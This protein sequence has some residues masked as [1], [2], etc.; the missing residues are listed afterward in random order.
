MREN[1][2]NQRSNPS[3]LPSFLVDVNWDIFIL[4]ARAFAA[5]FW[6]EQARKGSMKKWSSTFWTQK[7]PR[8]C[9]VS[10]E[11]VPNTSISD[12]TQ[13]KW[14]LDPSTRFPLPGKNFNK[15][16]R[17]VWFE[18]GLARWG[19][20]RVG[21]SL[22]YLPRRN[23]LIPWSYWNEQ[24]VPILH[25]QNSLNGSLV[26]L[27]G[28]V[29][30]SQSVSRRIGT[31]NMNGGDSFQSHTSGIELNA[32]FLHAGTLGRSLVWR[33][34]GAKRL[35]CIVCPKGDRCWLSF[36]S[37]LLVMG[38]YCLPILKNWLISEIFY[39]N[40]WFLRSLFFR[41]RLKRRY[42]VER[43]LFLLLLTCSAWPW[44]GP[45]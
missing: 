45:A 25:W 37:F 9:L 15:H 24:R 43:S 34:R 31:K 7:A 26:W 32:P 10:T 36:G 23:P 20:A 5:N 40:N 8:M 17:R 2:S 18:G 12:I 30:K 35:H 33:G 3:L 21:P 11:F 6:S 38:W 4:L 22:N 14:F 27:L 42:V 13:F 16:Q 44:L 28:T 39:Q 1:A 29:V 19:E 41:D